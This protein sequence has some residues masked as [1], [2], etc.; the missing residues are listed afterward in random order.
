MATLGDLR[1]VSAAAT[2]VKCGAAANARLLHFCS[3]N[4]RRC[5]LMT[6]MEVFVTKVSRRERERSARTPRQC[7]RFVAPMLVGV[8]QTLCAARARIKT[9]SSS[10]KWPTMHP[11]SRSRARWLSSPPG[12][13]RAPPRTLP[14]CEAPL[15][16]PRRRKHVCRRRPLGSHATTNRRRRRRNLRSRCVARVLAH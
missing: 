12:T 10:S 2:L 15:L 14:N 8:S 7:E 4:R 16:P 11:S 3:S 5:R 13:R 9:R 6:M 1:R